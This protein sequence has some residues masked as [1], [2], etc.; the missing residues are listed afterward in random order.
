MRKAKIICTIGPASDSQPILERLLAAGMDAARLNFSHGSH[1][2]HRRA[3]ES[4]RDAAARQGVVVAIM[5]DLQ[6]PRIRIGNIGTE[7]ITVAEGHC[8]RLLPAEASYDPRAGVHFA[9]RSV[10]QAGVVSLPVTYPR[11]ADDVKPGA[12][13]LVDDGLIELSATR[14]ADRVVECTVVRG[15]RIASHK[16]MNLPGTAISEPTLTTKDREDLRFGIAMRVDYVALSFVRGPEDI[17]AARNLVRDYGGETPLIAKIERPEAVATLDAILDEADGVMVARGDLGVEMGPETVP[18]LQKRIIKE[19][20]RR[21]RLVV[22]ATQMLESMTRQPNPTRAEASDVANA[23][24]D[25]TDA[26][27]L[28]A[29]TS[30]GRYPVEAV[31]VMERI[32]STTEEGM[33]SQ[34]SHG[35]GSPSGV[36]SFQEAICAAASTM[37]SAIGVSAIVAFSESGVTA[38]LVSKKRPDAPIIGITPDEAVRQRMALY[39]GVVPI[40]MPRIMDVEE[41]VQRMEQ[42]LKEEGFVQSGDRVIILSG[43]LA[44]QRGGT[45]TLKVHDIA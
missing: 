25:G 15:G 29:E 28:S 10:G 33:A 7:G 44:G 9:A 12:R 5:Q 35:Q 26:V 27:M 30:V 31:R 41:R 14:V 36:V 21:R 38:R 6:G 13:V 40:V 34:G 1:E 20:N 23:I 42:R 39:P 2:S 24:F 16:G 43:T 22:T 18:L 37:A 32:V 17:R 11:L 45:N 4:I 3:I 19:A 8:V